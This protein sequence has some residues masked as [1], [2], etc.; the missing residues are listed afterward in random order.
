[1]QPAEQA[2]IDQGVAVENVTEL[3]GDDALELVAFEQLQGA[4]RDADHRIVVAESGGESVDATLPVHDVNVRDRGAG[5]DR[6]LLDHVE[7]P[8]L[9]RALAARLDGPPA[10]H[11]GQAAAAVAEPGDFID[12]AA[13][14]HGEGE[15]G[16]GEEERQVPEGRHR[17][18]RRIGDLH[19]VEPARDQEDADDDNDKGRREHRDKSPC[20]L[21]R[22]L[23]ALE[24]VAHD[25][26]RFRRRRRSE[27]DALR[28]P[29]SPAAGPDRS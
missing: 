19:E 4:F 18:P 1:M 6:H 15:C 8:A 20:L 14:N 7:Q 9:L 2:D 26:R 25:W 3:V 17:L 24:K 16:D 23:L 29:R 5:G 27:P 21:A 28:G 22:R 13:E 11:F 10:E 12:G